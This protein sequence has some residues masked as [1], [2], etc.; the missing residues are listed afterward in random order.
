M[1]RYYYTNH[2][3]LSQNKMRSL[4]AKSKTY[5]VS[6]ELNGKFST[7]YPLLLHFGR[8]EN[9]QALTE[10]LIGRRAYSMG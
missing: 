10:F 9:I 7:N 5:L 6:K 8:D 3:T 2:P 1:T 4:I